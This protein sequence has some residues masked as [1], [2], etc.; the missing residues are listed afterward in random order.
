MTGRRL[1]ALVVPAM[2]LAACGGPTGTSQPGTNPRD[3]S[4]LHFPYPDPDATLTAADAGKTVSI[5][6]GGLVEVDLLGRPDRHWAPIQVTGT[7]VRS[8]GTQAMTPTVG[9]RLGEYCG[10]TPGTVTLTSSAESGKWTAKI[11]IR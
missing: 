3:C 6:A 5:S 9:S 8:L 7:G 4:T 2:L 10:V 1:I 11:R